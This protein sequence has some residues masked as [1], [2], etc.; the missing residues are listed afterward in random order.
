LNLIDFNYSNST[1]I[2]CVAKEDLYK[3]QT[4]FNIPVE[5]LITSFDLYPFKFE[6]KDA[7]SEAVLSIF[8]KKGKKLK[9]KTEQ[10]ITKNSTFEM[11]NRFLFN[12]QLMFILHKDKKEINDFLIKNR[13]S[14]YLEYSNSN[15]ITKLEEYLY[16]LPKVTYTEETY[17]Q[18]D[19]KFSNLVNVWADEESNLILSTENEIFQSVI[20]IIKKNLTNDTRNTV[21]MT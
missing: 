8:K 16:S 10:E 1:G 18:Y 4:T 15:R 12:Y 13:L 20:T 6:L 3:G 19:I 7:I 14:Y 21:R 9:I 11:T 5:Y 17:D 2:Y